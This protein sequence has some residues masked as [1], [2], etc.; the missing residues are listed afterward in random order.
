MFLYLSKLLPTLI[1]PIGATCI[2]ILLALILQNPRRQKILLGMAFCLLFLGG[3]RWVS[4]G[5]AQTLEWRYLPPVEIP[6]ADVIIILGGGEHGQSYPRPIP[7]IGGAGDRLIYAA[8]LYRQKAAPIVLFTG[9]AIEWLS[10]DDQMWRGVDTL[11]GLMGVPADALWLETRSRNTY[12]N[13]VEC[14][15][16]LAEKG[17][18]RAILVTSAVHMPRAVAIFR[19]Q[20]LEVIPA[21]V[22]YTVTQAEWNQFK[23][24]SLS[25]HLLFLL[26]SSESLEITSRVLKE[27]VGILVYKL[28]GWL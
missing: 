15:A 18:Q 8:W 12:E 19:H 13:A 11:L 1:Y 7:E 9:G 4:L 26:P 24:A 14:K 21:P 6:Q 25:S 27:Y 5:L 10:A 23:E 16:I 2:L 20:G 17:L 28:R 3:N 22:D